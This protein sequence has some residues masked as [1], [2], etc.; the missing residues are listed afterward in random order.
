MLRPKS[1]SRTG[2]YGSH[3][4]ALVTPSLSSVNTTPRSVTPMPTT[5]LGVN[6]ERVAPSRVSSVIACLLNAAAGRVRKHYRAARVRLEW[7]IGERQLP[8][9]QPRAEGRRQRAE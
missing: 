3:A 7:V 1:T 2:Q 9:G 6:P 4:S 5:R 8:P